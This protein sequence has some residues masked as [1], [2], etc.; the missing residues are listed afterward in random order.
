MAPFVF[1]TFYILY[2]Y[3]AYGNTLNQIIFI[4]NCQIYQRHCCQKPHLAL[5]SQIVKEI[6]AMATHRYYRDSNTALT[7]SGVLVR[8]ALLLTEGEI[9][10]SAGRKTTYTRE[11][12][13]A[14]AATSNEYCA[15][16]EVKFFTDHDYSQKARIG[17]VTG[18]FIAREITD[19]DLPE[20]ADRSSIGKYAIFNDGIEIR[21]EKA[22]A[23]YHAKLLKELSIGIILSGDTGTI[24]E[25]SA[26][27]WG[28]VKE[29]HIYSGAPDVEVKQYAYSFESQIRRSQKGMTEDD[30]K[31]MSS[32][33]R[34]FSAF[35]M[36]MDNIV[37]AED[38]ELPKSRYK[39]IKSTVTAFSDYL[40]GIYAPKPED[41]PETV[42][43]VMMEKPMTEETKTYSADEIQQL[44]KAEREK[45]TATLRKFSALKDRASELNA[46]GK[47]SKAKY[48][49]TFEGE[50]AFERNE[51]AITNGA[52]EQ[53]LNYVDEN[54]TP[55]PRLAPSVYG[56]TPLPN[57]EVPQRPE[58]DA[59]AIK[60]RAAAIPVT[61]VSY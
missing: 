24:F 28:A 18:K 56:A 32:R 6:K 2:P 49:A 44:I 52:L 60:D 8:P 42:P 51:S 38:S 3:T 53:F 17:A 45:A 26:V 37:N 11:R 46:L 9:T 58:A 59:K 30:M 50:D 41:E 57:Q 20:N 35:S 13:D 27:P 48:K 15:T 10:D 61:K 5:F 43:I 25:V 7:E 39:M 12:L 14:I 36:A 33:E 19:L 4:T 16:Q 34:G 31:S 1:L 29:A 55:D 23:K 22:I 21:D 40:M 47:L 54:I